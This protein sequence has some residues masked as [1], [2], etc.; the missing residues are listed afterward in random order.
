M[1]VTF[2]D[3]GRAVDRLDLRA[4]FQH[5]VIGAEAHGAALVVADLALDRAV[6]LDPFLHV[7]DHRLEAFAAGLVVEFLRSRRLDAAEVP[8]RLDHRHLHA[9]TDAEV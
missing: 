6:A 1:A 9:E 7:V 2:G 4:G 8:R 3:A 5:R